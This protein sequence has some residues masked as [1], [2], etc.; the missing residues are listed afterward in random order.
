MKKYLP[1]KEVGFKKLFEC[2][3]NGEII[4]SKVC[5]PSGDARMDSTCQYHKGIDKKHKKISG[6]DTDFVWVCDI[7]KK[8]LMKSLF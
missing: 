7:P 3:L 2:P 8:K 4:N 6:S 5:I 1:I